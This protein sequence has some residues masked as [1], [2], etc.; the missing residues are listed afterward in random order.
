MEKWKVINWEWA[1]GLGSGQWTRMG[2][3]DALQSCVSNWVVVTKAD[4]LS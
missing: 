3:W 2:F 4:T 1:R